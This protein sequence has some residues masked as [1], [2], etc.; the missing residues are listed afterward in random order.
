MVH[1]SAKD[2][3]Q[4]DLVKQIAAYLKK[5]GKVKVP[6][7]ADMIKLA[8]FNELPPVDPDWYF[9]RTASI[10]RHLYLRSPA[11]VKSF[12]KIYG[13]RKRNGTA[14]PHFCIAAGG[15]LRKCLQTL[16]GINWVEKHPEGG[17]VLTKTGRKDLDR[18]AS[19]IR[20]TNKAAALSV[21]P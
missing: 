8:R 17:R 7:S 18:I 10:A 11:G 15:A 12:K 9:V 13:A 19:H 16:E 21:A 3:D 4:H 6:E 14:P 1:T 20:A 2:V 5:G